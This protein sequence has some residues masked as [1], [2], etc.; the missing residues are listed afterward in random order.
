VLRYRPKTEIVLKNLTFEVKAGEKIG[1]VGRT[2]AG[3]STI[4]L[5]LS[6]I[7]EIV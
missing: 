1:V 5:S 6:R 7:V 3:K 4:C 2:G